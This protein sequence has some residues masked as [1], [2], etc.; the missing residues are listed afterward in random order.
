MALRDAK[1]CG[2]S[3]LDSRVPPRSAK[4]MSWEDCVVLIPPESAGA[5]SHVAMETVSPA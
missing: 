4:N 1:P 2:V 3:V 5:Y